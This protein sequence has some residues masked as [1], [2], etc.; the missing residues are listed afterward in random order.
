MSC[1][2][3]QEKPAHTSNCACDSNCF[4]VYLRNT[5][6]ITQMHTEALAG[7]HA[8]MVNLLRNITGLDTVTRVETRVEGIQNDHMTDIEDE[9]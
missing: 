3:K 2:I 8:N 4:E 1:Y 7:E 5:D 9:D 6:R